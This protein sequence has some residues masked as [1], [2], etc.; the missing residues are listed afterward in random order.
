[1]DFAGLETRIPT[2][3]IAYLTAHVGLA[4]VLPRR[5]SAPAGAGRGAVRGGRGPL[6]GLR[7]RRRAHDGGRI[8]PRRGLP[9]HA[10]LPR[11][12]RRLRRD[13]LLRRDRRSGALR[14]RGRGAATLRGAPPAGA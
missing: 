7:R 6:G 14:P 4:A 2:R 10:P 9:P 1:R 3:K 11:R 5:R 12:R 8:V 13:A